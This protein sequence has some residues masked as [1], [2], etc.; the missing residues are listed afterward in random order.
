MKRC[1]VFVTMILA[2][3][4]LTA[5][6]TTGA[7]D[8][9]DQTTTNKRTAAPE[10]VM[11]WY[12]GSAHVGAPA[13]ATTAALVRA[14]G[15]AQNFSFATALVALLG[16]EAA[17]VELTKLR[18]QYGTQAV[19]QFLAG[20]DYAVTDGLKRARAA[21]LTLPSAPMAL[22]SNKLAQA[23]VEAGTAQNGTFWAGRMLDVAL[24]HKVHN[25]VMTDI[26]ATFGTEAN[27]LMHQI[28]NQAMYDVAQVLG[29]RNVK[30][31]PLH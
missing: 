24:S 7:G 12:G 18:R 19:K 6:A 20:M 23:L 5:C 8:N 3:I 10:Q 14:G 31:A 26:N 1:F 28:L 2:A 13:L 22:T 16:Q 11:N 25:Q 21:G 17:N 30:L 9:N 15:G 27:L 29:M 4:M